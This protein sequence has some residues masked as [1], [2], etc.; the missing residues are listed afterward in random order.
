MN[1]IEELKPFNE[2]C[3]AANVKPSPRQ[4]KK[5]QKGKGIARLVKRGHAEPLPDGFAHQGT[6]MKKKRY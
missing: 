6:P 4:Y 1:V 3:K 5:W 2:D